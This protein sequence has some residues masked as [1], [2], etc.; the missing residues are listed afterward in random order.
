MYIYHSVIERKADLMEVSEV[1][2]YDGGGEKKGNAG[3]VIGILGNEG[4]VVGIV[5]RLAGNGGNVTFGIV[6][7]IFGSVGFGSVGF[8]RVGIWGLGRGGGKMGL[9]SGGSVGSTGTA[10][11]A[12]VSRRWRAA[13]PMSM[14]EMES[15]TSK[16]IRREF[17]ETAMV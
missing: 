10:G 3:K 14:L 11:G 9:G 15:D 12:G 1:L 2:V 8:G 5:G 7:G 4:I 17:I 16:R 13:W 6:V